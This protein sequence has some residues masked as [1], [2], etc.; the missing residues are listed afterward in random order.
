MRRDAGTT[1]IELMVVIAVLVPL[2][3]SLSGM[4]RTVTR[5]VDTNDRSSE[6][7]ERARRTMQRIGQLL[8]PG[9][10]SSFEVQAIEADV[11]ALR[12]TAVGEWISPTDLQPA[13]ALRFRAA[14]GLLSINAALSTP[15]RQISF[16]LE[17]GEAANGVDD[18]G[19]GLVDEGDVVLVYGPT[20]VRLGVFE[21]CDFT[22]DGR[23][24]RVTLVCARPSTER[25]YRAT[26]SQS[27]YV[28]NN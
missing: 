13:Q 18:D 28:R 7:G 5:T 23:Y 10:L 21:R 2:L 6:V 22:F 24:L 17:A 11:L 8:R 20:P 9:K 16:E 25:V 1:L 3:L 15:P 14:E 27:F 12:A 26:V 19:D 4:G